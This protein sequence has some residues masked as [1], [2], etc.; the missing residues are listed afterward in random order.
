MNGS[1][2]YQIHL[3]YLPFVE[4]IPEYEIYRK[5]IT[6]PQEKHPDRENV[7]RY[8]LPKTEANLEDRASYW[9]ALKSQDGFESFRV[10]ASFNNQ[11]TI[12]TLYKSLGEQCKKK[13]TN[14]RY[15]LSESGFVR[16]IHFNMKNY[17][18]GTEELIIQPYYLR[19]SSKFGI[20]ADFHFRKN[21]SIKFSRRVLQLS[22]SLDERFRRNLDFYVDR[23]A[24][25]TEYLKDCQNVLSVLQLPGTTQPV[26]LEQIF[27]PLPATRLH[28]KIYIFSNEHESRSQFTGLKDYGPLQPLAETPKLVFIFREQ[29]RQSAR[30]L[31]AS[32]KGTSSRERY[33]F[34][35][36]E[37]LFKTPIE[38]DGNPIVIP[39]FSI[40]AMQMALSRINEEKRLN[41]PILILPDNEDDGY[42]NHKAVFTH[43]GR[44]SQVCTLGV[45]QD[46]STLKWS[47]ANI[48]LQI[49]CKAGGMPWKVKP[50]DKKSLIIGISQS[51]KLRKTTENT[52]IEKYFAFS[53]MTDSSGLFQKIQVLGESVDEAS[54]L[55]QLRQKLKEMLVSG[56]KEYSQVVI[57]TSFR[58]KQQEIEEVYSVVRETAAQTSSHECKFAVVKVNHKSRFFGANQKINSLVPFEGTSVKLGGGEYLVWFEGIF[59]DKPTVTKAFPGPTHLQF[60]R[61]AEADNISDDILLQDLV[62]LSGANWRGFN[63]KSA[64]VSVFYCHLVADLVHNF[65]EHGLPL[66]AV[67]DLRPWFL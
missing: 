56:A 3:N 9:I 61:V 1:N 15:W 11:L 17:K 4:E 64:P 5:I 42:L 35:G 34:P 28:P 23:F 21:R 7:H 49:F 66:P 33:S 62:N 25:I 55:T 20:L 54:Y 14:E 58:L 65:Q 22:L 40:G 63:A 39:D 46:E 8:S 12:W 18:E 6:N 10:K 52:I 45:I 30:T 59:P 31:A 41:V 48:A 53:I 27:E 32:L 51:H 19:A 36:F 26:I 60:L 29:D 57:H 16:E 37:Q 50:T 44:A 47:V 38:I 13:L 43:A 67:E 24:K 2:E